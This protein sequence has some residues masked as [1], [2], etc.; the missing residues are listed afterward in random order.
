MQP[1]VFYRSILFEE[2]ER[3]IARKFFRCEPSVLTIPK[4]SLVIARYSVLPFYVDVERDIRLNGSRLLNSFD[5]HRFAADLGNYTDVLRDLTPRTYSL[6]EV[7]E[8]GGPFVVKGETN[9]RRNLWK[10]HMFAENKREAVEVACRLMNDT[11]IGQQ[12]I[13]V[14]DY[15]PLEQFLVGLD[16]VPVAREF[17]FFVLDGEV[18]CGGYYWTTHTDTLEDMRI[19][20]PQESEVPRMFLKK[21]T[22]LIGEQIRFYAVDIARTQDG[23]WIVIELNDGQMAGL[24]EN[25]PAVLYRRLKEKLVA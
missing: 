21:V 5:Q 1:V 20:V 13:Y 7:P 2:T 14:R 22:G 15:V 11:M 12:K 25:D 23:R 19:A 17:R 4:D 3:E 9:S 16:G 10:T 8:N 18:L 6:E 24:S